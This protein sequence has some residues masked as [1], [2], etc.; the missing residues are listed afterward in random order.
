MIQLDHSIRAF[1]DDSE[2]LTRPFSGPPGLQSGYRL[3]SPC[4]RKSAFH[5]DHN[6]WPPAGSDGV[7]SYSCLLAEILVVLPPAALALADI[8]V[9]LDELDCADEFH[10]RESKLGFHAKPKRRSM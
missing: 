4:A 8:F 3:R 2:G 7:E 6:G 9:I 10:H 1:C 5:D